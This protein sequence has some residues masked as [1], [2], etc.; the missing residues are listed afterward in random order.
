MYY[1]YWNSHNGYWSEV[2]K[3]SIITVCFNS[4][5]TIEDT[6]K[7]VLN[8]TYENYEY[9][10]IDGKST[11]N[12]LNIVKEYEKK[13]KGKMKII[14]DK[15]KGIYDAMNKGINLST[16]DIIGIINSDDILAHKN[17]F[18]K[19]VASF[20]ND[21]DVVYSDVLYC[22]ENFTKVIR[23]YKSGNLNKNVQMI[24]HPTMYVKKEVFKEIGMYNIKYKVCADYDFVIRLKQKKYSYKYVDDYFVLMRM[25]G[26]SNGLKGYIKNY[27][28]CVNVLKSNN[29][30]F[31]NINTLYRSAKTIFQH[32][33]GKIFIKNNQKTLN[34]ISKC[35]QKKI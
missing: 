1:Y 35:T 7:S 33:L 32:L 12:T 5:A 15:D 19:V 18:K 22:N 11:D 17:V 9:L 25:G 4:E 10:I 31:A 30:K 2:M 24:A 29:I 28:D 6:I 16:G 26:T 27:K 8:Q 13:F 34:E 21:I 3:I 20:K 23:K 14:S